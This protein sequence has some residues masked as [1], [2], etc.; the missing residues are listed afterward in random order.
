MGCLPRQR[1]C[2]Y[3]PRLTIMITNDQVAMLNV[4]T[5][6]GGEYESKSD[7]VRIFIREYE[8]LDERAA[9]LQRLQNE[10]RA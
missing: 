5:G 2:A 9:D 1:G 4:K 10:K 7:T 6:D 3:V 8:Y